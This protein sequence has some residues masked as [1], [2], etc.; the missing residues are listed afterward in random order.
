VHLAQSH[1]YSPAPNA[2]PIGRP[3]MTTLIMTAKLNDVDP[4]AWLGDVLARI[5]DPQ[6]GRT[7]AV[8]LGR[9]DRSQR[10]DNSSYRW[11]S[12]GHSAHIGQDVVIHYRWHPLCGQSTRCIRVERRATGEFVHVELAPGVVTVLS[13]WKLDA[14]YCA[15]LKVGAPQVTLAALCTLHE[16]LIAGESLLV[17]ADGNIVT[18]EAQ[19]GSAVTT[20]TKD[21]ACLQTHSADGTT[22]ARSRSRRRTTSGHDTGGAPSRAESDGAAPARGGRRSNAGG[23]R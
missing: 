6:A 20:R 14:V 1:G 13:A 11:Q 2:V 7:S 10:R 12:R 3:A 17:S 23:Q 21:G 9:H 16:L 8:E 4:Q 15:G 22:P 18:Q 19:D 5:N